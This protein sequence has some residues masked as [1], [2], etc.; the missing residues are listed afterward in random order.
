MKKDAVKKWLPSC[1]I[2]LVLSLCFFSSGIIRNDD[3]IGRQI[4]C[5]SLLLVKGNRVD[6]VLIDTLLHDYSIILWIDSSKC[7]AC[8]MEHLLGFESFYDVCREIMGDRGDFKVIISPK[9]DIGLIVNDIKFQDYPFD[10]LVDFRYKM[11]TVLNCNQRL[12]LVA[13][14]G[15]VSKYYRL[16]NRESDT[17]KL[18]D[19][20]DYLAQMYNDSGWYYE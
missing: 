10:V 8:E 4:E 1:L 5:D 13:K 17:R 2:I 6:M 9:D 20:L 16:E 3:I 14:D 11:S 19:C 12:L 15:M 7:A 18:K